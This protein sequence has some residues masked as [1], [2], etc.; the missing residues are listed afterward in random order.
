MRASQPWSSVDG[1]LRFCHWLTVIGNVVS[2]LHN[3][4]PYNLRVYPTVRVDLPERSLRAADT[5][6]ANLHV[7]ASKRGRGD[8]K[9]K[10][11]SMTHGEDCTRTA[12]TTLL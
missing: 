3:G 4:L 7:I 5:R 2:W 12:S 1:V 9:V 6:A 8:S 10:L 11:G